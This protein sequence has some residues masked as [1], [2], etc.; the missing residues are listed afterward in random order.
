MKQEIKT[1]EIGDG[2]TVSYIPIPEFDNLTLA[3]PDSLRVVFLDST[4]VSDHD[5]E[6]NDGLNTAISRIVRD[7][8]PQYD[9]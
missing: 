5:R 3:K 4:I 2:N 8:Y 1:V 9:K 6:I 7:K